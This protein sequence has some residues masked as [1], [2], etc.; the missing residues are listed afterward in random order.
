MKFLDKI[1]IGIIYVILFIPIS[2]IQIIAFGFNKTN[3]ENFCE[4]KNYK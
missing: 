1:L 2:L 4:R 3:R